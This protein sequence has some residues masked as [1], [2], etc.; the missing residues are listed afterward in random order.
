MCG[1]QGVL[2][3]GKARDLT[4]T[5]SG[6]PTA[7]VSSVRQ[8]P[9]SPTVTVND[10]HSSQSI[11][12]PSSSLQHQ[13]QHPIVPCH[14]SVEG[15]NQVLLVRSQCVLFGRPNGQRER[16]GLT[17]SRPRPVAFGQVKSACC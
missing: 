8:S 10:R 14:G 15:F 4:S 11:A 7:A 5:L 6:L 2:R 12:I 1:L 17:K 16:G 3:A 13:Q 9:G